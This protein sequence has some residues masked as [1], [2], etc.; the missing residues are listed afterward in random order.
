MVFVSGSQSSDQDPAGLCHR[1]PAPTGPGRGLGVG[2]EVD[3]LAQ[4]HLPTGL[5]TNHGKIVNKS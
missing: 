5:Q 1:V 4:D 2:R 3:N